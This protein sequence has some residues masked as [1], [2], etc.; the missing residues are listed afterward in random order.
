MRLF[1]VFALTSTTVRN[2][3]RRKRRSIDGGGGYEQGAERVP[4]HGGTKYDSLAMSR[5]V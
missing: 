1:R 2:G 4:C 5:P 3:V